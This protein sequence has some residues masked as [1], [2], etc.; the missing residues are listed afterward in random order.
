MTI[1][2]CYT[3]NNAALIKMAHSFNNMKK[4]CQKEDISYSLFKEYYNKYFDLVEKNSLGFDYLVYG[5]TLL[6]AQVILLTSDEQESYN[7]ER[8]IL[9]S[10]VAEYLLRNELKSVI[11]PKEIY[12]NQKVRKI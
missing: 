10:F 3:I 9:S 1:Y 2:E 4:I 6:N 12:A 7:E 11:N 5:Y 8:K